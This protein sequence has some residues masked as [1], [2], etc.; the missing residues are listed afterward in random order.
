MRSPGCGPT[1][2]AHGRRRQRSEFRREY[3]GLSYSDEP[4][5]ISALSLVLPASPLA[6]RRAD[7]RPAAK[8]ATG[9]SEHRSRAPIDPA[10]IQP[11]SP[12]GPIGC[13]QSG[14]PLGCPRRPE[15]R[16][17]AR[18][19]G[20]WSAPRQRHDHRGSSQLSLDD[21]AHPDREPIWRKSSLRPKVHRKCANSSARQGVAPINT[22]VLNFIDRI[23]RV[24]IK[25]KSDMYS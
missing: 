24:L 22:I 12:R 1:V 4:I 19:G 25:H 21:H 11:S 2:S 6:R 20:W 9:S 5:R 13:V 18:A 17:F 3:F 16:R 23:N 7:L 8:G 10:S 14:F 15:P